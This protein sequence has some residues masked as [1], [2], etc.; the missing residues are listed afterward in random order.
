MSSQCKYTVG[1][2]ALRNVWSKM[3]SVHKCQSV[4]AMSAMSAEESTEEQRVKNESRLVF[5]FQFLFSS[6]DRTLVSTPKLVSQLIRFAE[7]DVWRMAFSD[8]VT[9][10]SVNRR[11]SQWIMCRKGLNRWRR[12]LR[13]RWAPAYVWSLTV[14]PNEI[15]LFGET[16]ATLVVSAQPWAT[17]SPVHAF[18]AIRAIG[19]HFWLSALRQP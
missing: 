13:C 8:G 19:C 2:S 10:R 15:R 11:K 16:M 12:A 18:R 1:V 3:F 6:S 7:R 4:P 5:G 9:D 17:V 14:R